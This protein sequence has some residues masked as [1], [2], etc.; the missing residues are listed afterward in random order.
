[1]LKYLALRM[2]LFKSVLS[3]ASPSFMLPILARESLRAASSDCS[4]FISRESSALLPSAWKGNEG[5]VS[6]IKYKNIKSAKRAQVDVS[7]PSQCFRQLGFLLLQQLP[8]NLHLLLRL[9]HCRQLPT[10]SGGP[11]LTLIQLLLSERNN[12][13]AHLMMMIMICVCATVCNAFK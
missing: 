8:L 12:M 13:H 9:A 1:M 4:L 7:Y 6:Q 10:L 2:Y 3:W 5:R 11:T